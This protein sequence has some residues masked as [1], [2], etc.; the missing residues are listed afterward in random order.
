MSSSAF[1]PTTT[2][3]TTEVPVNVP[4]VTAWQSYTPTFDGFGTPTAVSALWRRIGD[5]IEVSCNFTSGTPTS[6]VATVSLPSGLNLDASKINGPGQSKILG[7]AMR[8]NSVS[9]PFPASTRGPWIVTDSKIVS[10]SKIYFTF[11]ANTASASVFEVA[12]GSSMISSGEQLT[13]EFRAP[14][15]QWS[16]GVTTLADRALEEYAWNS[17]DSAASNSSSFSYGPDGVLFPNISTYG[18]S[19]NK[20]VKFTT[21]ILSTDLIM[22]EYQQSSTGSWRSASARFPLVQAGSASYGIEV[23]NFSST[24]VDIG[25][26]EN[27]AISTGATYGA[28]GELWS[29]YRTANWKWRVRKVSSGAQVGYP[30]STKNIVGATDGVAPVTG[31][32]GEKVTWSVQPITQSVTVSET[33]WTNSSITLGAGTWLLSAQVCATIQLTATAGNDSELNVKITDASNNEINR[34]SRSI[35]ARTPASAIN[36]TTQVISLSTVV[37]ISSTTTY[38]IRVRKQDNVGTA[39]VSVYNEASNYSDFFAIRIA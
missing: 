36:L 19:I 25:F 14:I 2:Q 4:V 35:R 6:A 3:V 34:Q 21:P 9:T 33:D 30:I 22:V 16:S 28:N 29:A 23:R 11:L 5:S 37:S 26:R 8:A 20:R 1:T 13:L 12:T 17:D 7:I 24:E 39:A 31:M 10:T 38:K 32:L 18:A 15:S 27:G